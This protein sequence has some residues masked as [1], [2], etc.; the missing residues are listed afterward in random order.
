MSHYAVLET[1]KP[2]SEVVGRLVQYL[3]EKG[4]R[5]TL[6]AKKSGVVVIKV[7]AGKGA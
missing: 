2:Q 7:K 1:S 5:F 6:K 3:I 4:D